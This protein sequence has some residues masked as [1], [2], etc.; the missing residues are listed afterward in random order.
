MNHPLRTAW[1]L[2]N[3][4]RSLWL[5]VWLLNFGLALTLALLPALDLIDAS[6]WTAIRDVAD[7]LDGWLFLEAFGPI[8]GA[9]VGLGDGDAAL[10]EA[11]TAV[12]Q[13]ATT[14]LIL[15]P[16]LAWVSHAWLKGGILFV[17]EQ[18]P[19]EF[20]WRPFFRACWR[21]LLPFLL[22]GFLQASATLLMLILILIVMGPLAGA[23]G[24]SLIHI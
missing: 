10:S 23:L 22:A 20:R 5:V 14:L 3:R 12:L 15:I 24:L 8:L 21:W 7:G 13:Q 9:Q 4:Y 16:I 17:Y 18:T 1:E 2:V 19:S 11:V 6:H